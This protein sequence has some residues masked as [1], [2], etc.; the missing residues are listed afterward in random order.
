MTI[1]RSMM[2]FSFKNCC[3]A[4]RLVSH[5]SSSR[6]WKLASY[7][8]LSACNRPMLTVHML[9]IT[10]YSYGFI[11]APPFS[12]LFCDKQASIPAIRA[13]QSPPMAPRG[14]ERNLAQVALVELYRPPLVALLSSPGENCHTDQ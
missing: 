13:C 5:E 11:F 7:I 8:A 12:H 6:Q 9:K 3:H 2:Y 14:L 1:R 10:L 4:S